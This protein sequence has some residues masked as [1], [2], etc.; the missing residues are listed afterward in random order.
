[1]VINQIGNAV[2]PPMIEYIA[3]DLNKVKFLNKPQ[4]VPEIKIKTIGSD[5]DSEDD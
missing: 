2:P 4:S 1:M 5:S 3:N